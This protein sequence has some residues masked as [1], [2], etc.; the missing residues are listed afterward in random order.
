LFAC[1][2]RLSACLSA[3]AIHVPLADS[4]AIHVPITV[5][6]HVPP[7]D[8]LAIRVPIAVAIRVP[9]AVAIHV[10]LADSLAIMWIATAREAIRET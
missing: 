2:D 1:C 9:I 4:L 3:V 10:R 5:A 8:S 6:I 7:A